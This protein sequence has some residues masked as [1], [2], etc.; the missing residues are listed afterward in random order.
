MLLSFR[1]ME[2]LGSKSINYHYNFF[3]P[4]VFG[5]ENNTIFAYDIRHENLNIRIVIILYFTI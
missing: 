1:R 3:I 5:Y 2:R 4:M